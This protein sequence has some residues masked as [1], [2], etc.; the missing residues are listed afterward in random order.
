MAQGNKFATVVGSFGTPTNEIFNIFI[1]LFCSA[2]QG[3]HIILTLG[4]RISSVFAKCVKYCV[5]L[6]KT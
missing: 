2:E 1:F 3:E 4:S 6:K 5:K